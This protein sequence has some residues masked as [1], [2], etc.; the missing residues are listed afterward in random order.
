MFTNKTMRQ[1]N[2]NE[3]E[4]EILLSNIYVQNCSEKYITFTDIFR[5]KVLGL[6][7]DGVY[8]KDIGRILGFPEWFLERNTLKQNIKNWKKK[9][10]IEGEN[11]LIGK[12]KGRK[13]QEK[14]EVSSMT[15]EEYIQYLEAQI[16]AMSEV[17]EFLRK[18]KGKYP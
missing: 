14:T 3:K 8:W 15:Q 18:R 13:K 10:K 2:W 4:Q 7:R 6:H 9:Y 1:T 16:A 5:E 12:K 11:G 17:Q